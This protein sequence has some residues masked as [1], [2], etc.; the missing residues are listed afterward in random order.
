MKRERKEIVIIG[1]GFGGLWA[2]RDLSRSGAG[3]T[4]IDR[5]NYHT[6][7]PLLYQVGAAEIE[8]EQIAYPVRSIVRGLPNVR[9]IRSEVRGIDYEKRLVDITAGTVT[10]DYL[11]IATG[12]V[13]NYFNIPGTIE[14]AFSLKTL[15]EAIVLRN[16][17]LSCYE[18][19]VMVQDEALRRQL[20]TFIIVGSGP[21]GIEFAGTL[22][23]LVRGPL[24]RDFPQF[25]PGEAQ[26]ILMDVA[27]SV[28]QGFP[29]K[30][31]AYTAEKI[32]KMGIR[33]LLRHRVMRVS[34]DGVLCEGTG[35]FPSSTVVWTAGVCGDAPQESH[36][37]ERAPG[38]R[39]KVRPTLQVHGRDN[40]Y[41]IGDLA[42]VDGAPLPM[43]APAAT[44]QGVTAARNILRQME[45]KEQLNFTYKDRGAMVTIGRNTAVARIGRLSLRGFVAWVFWLVVH[46]MNLIGFRNK[47]I[48]MM[49]WAWSYIFFERAVRLILPSCC[50]DPL[51]SPCVPGHC[52]G[53]GRDA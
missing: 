41:C 18:R 49:T 16:H 14:S 9:F 45:G 6:F 33:V 34:P 35:F 50:D 22:S 31:S 23:E 8:P 19:A 37:L 25:H 4:L 43:I 40:V 13:T 10:Y 5:N 46:L 7:L 38:R 15:D 30:L 26:V 51:S 1:A 52:P 42:L 17:V 29:S 28:L 3:I 21:T 20:L 48:V 12:S 47:L 24:K 39:I 2:A 11:I 27:E 53:K 32:A 44:Q 36:A